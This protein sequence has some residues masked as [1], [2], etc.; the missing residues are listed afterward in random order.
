[1]IK[2]FMAIA[3]FSLSVVSEGSGNT[4][5]TPDIEEAILIMTGVGDLSQLPSEELESFMEMAER[6]L[7]IN[8]C[9]RAALLDSGLF[10]EYQVAA[11][12]D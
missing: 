8:R 4:A 9:S 3:L 11:V 10:S 6:P 12:L 7:R 1:M 2:E 5:H